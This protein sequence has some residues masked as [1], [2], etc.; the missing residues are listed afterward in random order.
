[1]IDTLSATAFA[2]S[3]PP[4]PDG[5][6]EILSLESRSAKTII[7]NAIALAK[8]GFLGCLPFAHV[9]K[10]EIAIRLLPEYDI[11]TLPVVM[12]WGR[13]T[14]G[15]TIAPDLS[16][17]VAGR[18][19]QMGLADSS[20]KLTQD[21]KQQLVEW[22]AQL[23][24]PSSCQ[25]ILEQIDKISHLDRYVRTGALW[26]A[27]GPDVPLYHALAI[28][29]KILPAPEAYEL[30][31]QAVD[32]IPEVDIVWR[33]Y[34]SSYNLYKDIDLGKAARRLVEGDDV[35]DPTYK[36]F[37]VG[38]NLGGWETEPLVRVVQWVKESGIQ[39][40]LPVD[41]WEA[42]QAYAANPKKYDGVLHLNFARRIAQENP[43][44]A[45]THAANAAMFFVR[46][47]R[48]TPL[49]AVQFA[50][51]LAQT[52]HWSHLETV[53]GWAYEGLK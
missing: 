43:V 17:F 38:I 35:F 53:L 47:T 29:W 26:A 15:T 1:M 46:A 11:E 14:E 16:H 22:A 51:E 19:A 12:C 32:E 41:L 48:K 45:Y 13:H 6:A 49:G 28:I 25:T 36:A 30:I 40:E 7:S 9:E 3:F 24:D 52:N 50:Y 8:R 2:K 44:L 10:D 42:A 23:G 37:I 18:I 27:A 39:V 4:I 31:L 20:Q 34:A 5:V 21:I 33:L